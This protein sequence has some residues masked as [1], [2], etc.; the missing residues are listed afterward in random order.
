MA[1]YVDDAIVASPSKRAI[2]SVTAELSKTFELKVGEATTFVGIEIYREKGTGA[3]KLSQASYVR[4]L[5]ETF[6]MLNA[7]PVSTLMTVGVKLPKLDVQ[8]EVKF[9]YR[10]AVGSLLFAAMVTRPDIANAVSQL[11]QHLCAFGEEHIAAVKRVMRYLRGTINVALE[12]E[13]DGRYDWLRGRQSR[14]KS[15][16]AT[17][18]DRLHLRAQRDGSHMGKSATKRSSSVDMRSKIYRDG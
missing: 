18:D 2:E 17:L 1:L 8:P 11:S 3:I 13:A 12:Y 5:L 6:D 7:K 16:D 4:K 14:R 10:E 15:C 9:P